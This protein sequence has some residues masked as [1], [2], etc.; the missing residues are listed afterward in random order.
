MKKIAFIILIAFTSCKKKDCTC[1]KI[2]GKVPVLNIVTAENV[3][4]EESKMYEIPMNQID[5]YTFGEE[6]CNDQI[7]K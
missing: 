7:V 1:F 4:T 2:T 5:N 3:C 6:V